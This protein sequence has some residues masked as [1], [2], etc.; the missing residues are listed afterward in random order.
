MQARTRKAALVIAAAAALALVAA[1][2]AKS[3]RSGTPKSSGGTLV[4]AGAGDPRNFDG[5]FNDDGESLR[6]IRQ[7]YDTLIQNKPGTA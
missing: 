1:G 2:C 4:F 3:N 6:V 7:L 5:I